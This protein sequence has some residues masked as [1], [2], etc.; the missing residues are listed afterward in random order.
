MVR[1]IV[2]GERNGRSTVLSDGPVGNTHDFV[3]V[4]G[5]RTT[6][7]WKADAVPTLP[8]TGP[9]RWRPSPAWCPIRT[10]RA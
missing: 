6:L 2:T 10:A 3:H 9:T 4:P 7:A 8:T 5:F 1:R